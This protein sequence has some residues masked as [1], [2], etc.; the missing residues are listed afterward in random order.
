MFPFPV[1]LT[2]YKL[3][4]MN[5]SV[6]KPDLIIK[7]IRQVCTIPA[8]DGGPQRGRRLGD[9]GIVEDAAIVIQDGRIAAIGPQPAI[10]TQFPAA[11]ESL[12]EARGRIVTP[13]LIDPHTHLIWAGD[14]ADEY[15]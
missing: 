3:C 5:R 14:R 7:N 15:E 6:M 12:L 13:G 11:D 1:E 2:G 9:L 4:F 8:H 10:L